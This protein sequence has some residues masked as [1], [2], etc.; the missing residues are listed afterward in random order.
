MKLPGRCVVCGHD[1]VWYVGHWRDPKKASRGVGKRHVCPDE[2]PVCG[3][4]MPYARERC[5]RR[6]GH[7]YEH[8]TLYAIENARRKGR[9][10]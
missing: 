9:V 10:A 5:A 8:R 7:G 3:A 6:P 4:F 2:R 1:V